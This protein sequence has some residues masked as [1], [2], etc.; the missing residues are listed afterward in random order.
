MQFDDVQ[1]DAD[2]FNEKSGD[3]D[4]APLMSEIISKE[5]GSKGN[6]S[7]SEGQ[8]EEPDQLAAARILSKRTI[9]NH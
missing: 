2:L 5:Y 8:L 7:P 6:N 9:S 3:E 4:E 1:K